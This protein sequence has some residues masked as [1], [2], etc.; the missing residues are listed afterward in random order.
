MDVDDFAFFH[1]RLAASEQLP[2]RSWL[3]TGCQ[4]HDILLSFVVYA[5]APIHS[6]T[7]IP[8]HYCIDPLITNDI[9]FQ[10]PSQR[11]GVGRGGGGKSGQEAR[12]GSPFLKKD[13]D[14][15]EK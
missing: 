15:T 2:K 14:V 1:I 11:K 9:T 12:N 3:W 8:S 5:A 7:S 4:V 6:R 13:T 10:L